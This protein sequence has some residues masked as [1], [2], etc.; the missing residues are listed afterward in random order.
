MADIPRGSE[1]PH[2][3]DAT[4]PPSDAEPAGTLGRPPLPGSPEA[5][6]YVGRDSVQL[7]HPGHSG[8]MAL[9]VSGH[10]CCALA[11]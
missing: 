3:K 4:I 5:P 9:A 10:E 7:D 2:L 1:E 11:T 6:L 8:V